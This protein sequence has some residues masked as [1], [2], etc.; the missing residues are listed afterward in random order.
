MVIGIIIGFL[1]GATSMIVIDRL[2]ERINVRSFIAG[3]HEGE[4]SITQS[5]EYCLNHVLPKLRKEDILD[6]PIEVLQE[7]YNIWNS[8][9]CERAEKLSMEEYNNLK[10]MGVNLA[11]AIS[12]KEASLIVSA[13]YSMNEADA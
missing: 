6:L 5:A 4:S 7:M 11:E 2:R 3:I 8:Q 1:V 12:T 9:Y 10:V 13:H